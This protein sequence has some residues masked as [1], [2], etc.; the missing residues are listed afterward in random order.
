MMDPHLFT[1]RAD[2]QGDPAASPPWLLGPRYGVNPSKGRAGRPTTPPTQPASSMCFAPAPEVPDPPPDASGAE[3]QGHHSRS[4]AAS[5][6][7]P[8][9]AD[10]RPRARAAPEAPQGGLGAS[11]AAPAEDLSPAS[12][13]RRWLAAEA[14]YSG[15]R[16][17]RAPQACHRGAREGGH[18]PTDGEGRAR[19]YTPWQ[20]C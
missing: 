18:G 17:T 15:T 10:E 7:T 3:V 2:H 14:P 20:W 5:E 9:G 19:G 8:A 13:W 4:P 1:P 12:G 11:Q 6:T 16:A